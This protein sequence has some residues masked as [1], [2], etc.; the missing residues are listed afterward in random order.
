MLGVKRG[1]G[2][3]AAEVGEVDVGEADFLIIIFFVSVFA[4]VGLVVVYEDVAWFD[5]YIAR[6]LA[7]C[8]R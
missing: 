6:V 7:I 4:G 1:F 3:G 8:T 2:D 5:V